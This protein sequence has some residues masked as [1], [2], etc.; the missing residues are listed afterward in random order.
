[1][2]IVPEFAAC[3]VCV[4]KTGSQAISLYLESKLRNNESRVFPADSLNDYHATLAEVERTKSL[5]FSVYDVWSFA[6][7]RNPFDR[8][9]S[10][11][12]ATDPLFSYAP[13]DTMANV[14][15]RLMNG[16]K[17]RWLYP[18]T[19][20]TA[21]V[22][23]IFRFEN[24]NEDMKLVM[25]RLGV[26]SDDVVPVVNESQHDR[27]QAYYDSDLKSMIEKLYADDFKAFG[28]EF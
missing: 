10:Y 19:F 3:F 15:Y 24:L 17:D 13:R 18:Q 8:F 28:Y 7:V 2:L 23:S 6:F 14:I 20:F 22:K 9:V 5:P 12:A 16:G 11:C 27:Y 21:G 26:P 4:P 1:M 25:E